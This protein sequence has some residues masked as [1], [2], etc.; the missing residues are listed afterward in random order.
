MT[1][2]ILNFVGIKQKQVDKLADILI[3]LLPKMDIEVTPGGGYRGNVRKIDC[4][5]YRFKIEEDIVGSY[6]YELKNGTYLAQLDLN[7]IPPQMYD[8]ILENIKLIY[9]KI[10]KKIK[11]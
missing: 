8:K 4:G 1:E 6:M 9:P 7:K 2:Q 5:I 11:E 3:A 10:F